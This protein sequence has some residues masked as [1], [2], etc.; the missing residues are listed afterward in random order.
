MTTMLNW[1]QMKV[2]LF[3]DEVRNIALDLDVIIVYKH[4]YLLLDLP[5]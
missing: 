2:P 5:T 3:E 4:E 1:F